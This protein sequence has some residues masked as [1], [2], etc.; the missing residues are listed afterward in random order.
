M[1]FP[2]AFKRS[3][4]E[5]SNTVDDYQYIGS[6][7]EKLGVVISKHRHYTKI[8]KIRTKS[9][10]DLNDLYKRMSEY[11]T[12]NF[13]IELLEDYKCNNKKELNMRVL[14]WKK[15]FNQVKMQNAT[16]SED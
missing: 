14:E 10:V 8:N 5:V 16:D 2:I 15:S 13:Y 11:G 3:V 6:T 9:A 1:N 7:V 4:E 12:H